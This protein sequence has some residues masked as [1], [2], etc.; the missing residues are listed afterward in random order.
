M[1]TFVA[2]SYS[3]MEEKKYSRVRNSYKRSAFEIQE[4]WENYFY[5]A[6]RMAI[7]HADPSHLSDVIAASRE[8]H[9]Y[10]NVARILHAMNLPWTVTYMEHPRGDVPKANKARLTM[11]RTNDNWSLAFANAMNALETQ[12]QKSIDL[13]V[14][15]WWEKKASASILHLFKTAKE[16]GMCAADFKEHVVELINKAA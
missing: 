15:K 2:R 4:K 13:P 16:K 7:V 9:Q 5:N 8:L 3:V 1:T 14:E 6:V 12:V 11:L 10:R